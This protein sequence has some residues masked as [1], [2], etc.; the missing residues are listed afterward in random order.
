MPISRASHAVYDTRYHIAWA[1]KSHKWIVRKDL[2]DLDDRYMKE[3]AISNELEIEMQVAE[4]HV[5]IAC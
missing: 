4:D 5:H 2:M 3:I 1:P